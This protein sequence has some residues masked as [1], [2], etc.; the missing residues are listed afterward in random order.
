[1]WSVSANS[2]GDPVSAAAV[3]F[4]IATAVFAA[5]AA[6]TLAKLSSR[7]DNRPIT[8]DLPDPVGRLL[9]AANGHDTGAFLASFTDDGVVDDWGREFAGADAIRGWSDREFIGVDVTLTITGVTAAGDETTLRA[10]VGGRG[11]NGPSQFTFVVRD[12]LISRMTIRE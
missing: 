1:V 7:L 6:M 8:D 9:D 2:D 5:S 3:P 4:A 10:E 11:F 12:G